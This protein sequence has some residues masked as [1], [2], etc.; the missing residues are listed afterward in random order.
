MLLQQ[1]SI[2]AASRGLLRDC[3]V[4]ILGYVSVL[5]QDIHVLH[6]HRKNA[7]E[8]KKTALLI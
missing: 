5:L 1:I 3:L 7:V 4:E 6:L 8:T 2:C